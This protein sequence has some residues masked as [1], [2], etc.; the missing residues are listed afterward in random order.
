MREQYITVR[1]LSLVKVK[2][3]SGCASIFWA[4]IKVSDMQTK[5]PPHQVL[6]LLDLPLRNC[7]SNHIHG[8]TDPAP[9]LYLPVPCSLYSI[10]KILTPSVFV[11]VAVQLLNI[12]PARTCTE[13]D[14]LFQ[15][16]DSY[17]D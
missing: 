11:V 14:A 7:T 17:D 1:A 4:V 8:F 3:M 9:V 5:S 16:V 12:L 10:L 2:C 13:N 6:Q 15:T